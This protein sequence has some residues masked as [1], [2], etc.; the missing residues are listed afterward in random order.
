[1]L[2]TWI[3]KSSQ[4]VP[5]R[6]LVVI[7]TKNEKKFSQ[8]KTCMISSPNIDLPDDPCS[9]T[10]TSSTRPRTKKIES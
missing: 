3:I 10:D 7:S 6:Y 2:E 4:I 5:I 1:M 9:H 8:W